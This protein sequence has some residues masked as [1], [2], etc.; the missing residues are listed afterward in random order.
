[1][2]IAPLVAGGVSTAFVGGAVG[3][4]Y[5]AT[6]YYNQ[7]LLDPDFWDKRKAGYA[8]GGALLGGLIAG[9]AMFGCFH[10]LGMPLVTAKHAV[11][12]SALPLVAGLP[13]LHEGKKR[14]R[15]KTSKR[16]AAAKRA[17][18]HAAFLF[19]AK[20]APAQQE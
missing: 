15:S 20:K 2:P 19:E 16:A 13:E 1:M 9:G 17:D 12:L 10:G 5:A 6:Q 11:H 7:S 14:R 4:G 8:A 3:G 18:Q